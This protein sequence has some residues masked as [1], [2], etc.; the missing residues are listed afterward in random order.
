MA[1][2]GGNW[3]A[4][5][6]QDAVMQLA[7][8]QGSKLRPLVFSK[9]ANSEKV[10]FERL[11]AT[12]AVAKTTRYTATPNV[13]M[14]HDRRVATLSD[15]HWATMHDWT[16]DVRMIVDP[17]GAYTKSGAWAMGRAID[18]L[19]ISAATGAA[20]DG[21]G[22]SVAF[23]SAQTVAEAGTTGMNLAKILEAKKI[24][25]ENEVEN[26]DRYFVLGS[27]ALQ[28]LLNVT[29]IKSS[30]YNSVKA[31]VEGQIDSYLGFRFVRS[32]RLAIA[33]NIRD[34]IA[35]QKSGLGLAIGKDM[36]T[37]IDERPDLSYGWQ[38]YMA[39]SMAATRVEDA[40]VVKVQAYEAP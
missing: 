30:D 4:Q 36:V 18:D 37:K 10:N 1:Y 24:L 6:Y 27:Q 7:Q 35:F 38:V 26:E 9:T 3:Y 39:W 11:G 32:E 2:S 28:D 5:Q 25:D 14:V 22:A 19:I 21:A 34:C 23:T 29:E 8:Q 20:T 31:L 33:T 12:A 40:K 13:E 16:D 17:K 15:Y